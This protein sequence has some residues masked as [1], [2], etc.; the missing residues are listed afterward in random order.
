MSAA[1]S[2][3]DAASARALALAA[4]HPHDFT[5]QYPPRREY[6]MERFRVA[7]EDALIDASALDELLV[8]VHVPFCARRCA[9]CNFAVDVDPDEARMER[10]VA[11]MERRLAQLA[12][13]VR[14]RVLGIDVGGGT[15]T[16]LPPRLLARLLA[17]VAPLRARAREH[18]QR[19]L[20]IETTPEIAATRPDV[21]DVLREHGV[22]R[23]SVGLQSGDAATLGALGRHRDVTLHARAIEALA[24]RGFA[25]VSADL[26][27]GLPGQTRASWLGDLDAAIALGTD[28]ITTYD[29]LY[30]GK[31]RALTRRTRTLPSPKSYGELY[32]AGFDRLVR[33]GLY[34]DYGSVNFSR[35]RGE[36]GTSA[37]FE[38]RLLDGTPYVGVGTYATSHAGDRWTFE[39]AAV[40]EWIESSQPIA[41]AYLLDR[42]ETVAKYLLLSLSFGRIDRD[43]FHRRF[44]APVELHRGR[45]LEDA[46]ALDLLRRDARGFHVRRFEDLPKVR[47][48]LHP[49]AAIAWLEQM[50]RTALAVVR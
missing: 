25:R 14:G 35:H 44:G 34:S 6:F 5:L 33:A 10:Y 42:D 3:V 20:S 2:L 48:L 4:E 31:G 47:A 18:V 24:R 30:R 36:T 16:R 13:R 50:R 21:L 9:Y 40:D 12:A 22:D 29:C 11:A 7:K 46:E 28:A 43:R 49:P 38:R 17:A 27:F 15:P 26:I 37:Y 1:R 41:D 8:Y 45:A 23:V 32:D 19:P 39:H